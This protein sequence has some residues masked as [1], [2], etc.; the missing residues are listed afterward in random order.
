MICSLKKGTVGRLFSNFLLDDQEKLNTCFIDLLVVVI[1]YIIFH[2]SEIFPLE[3][4]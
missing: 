3:M 1:N 2:F 4:Q